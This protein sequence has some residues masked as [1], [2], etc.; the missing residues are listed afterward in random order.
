LDLRD[1]EEKKRQWK[2]FVEFV[3]EDPNTLMSLVE[4]EPE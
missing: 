4:A 2:D 1:E 3:R